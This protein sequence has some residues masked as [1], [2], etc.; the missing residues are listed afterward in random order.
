MDFIIQGVFDELERQGGV[1]QITREARP[2]SEYALAPILPAREEDEYFVESANMVVRSTMA[3]IVAMDSP[4][5][6]GSAITFETKNERTFKTAIQVTMGEAVL[7]RLQRIYRRVV[8]G[9]GG[10]ALDQM[11]EEFLNYYKGVILQAH[12]DHE[13]Y[14]RGMALST[15]GLDLKYNGKHIEVDYG[16]PAANKLTTRTGNDAYG[17]SE[18]KFWA[19]R[20][21]ADRLLPGGIRDAICSHKTAMDII[22]NPVNSVRVVNVDGDNYTL[23]RVVNNNGV[24][25]DSFDTRDLVTLRVYRSEADLFDAATNTTKAIPFIPNGVVI[26]LGAPTVRGYVPGQGA[27]PDADSQRELGYIHVGPTVEGNG[28]PGRW[29]R[30]FRPENAPWSI[31]SQA[32]SN[33]MPVISNPKSIVIAS[34]ALQA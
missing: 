6:E 26:Y 15:G 12:F 9:G 17:G 3:G 29:G 27:R 7:R 20:Y 19:D 1:A 4:Y 2:S 10:N 31:A 14:L 13:E 25:N 24:I 5:P 16:V 8:E 30:T 32:V 28:L 33:I 34:T 22:H 11:V 18:S 21:E 23:Q